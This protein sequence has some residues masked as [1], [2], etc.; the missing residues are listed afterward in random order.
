MGTTIALVASLVTIA[1]GAMFLWT[2]R[3][4]VKNWYS[5]RTPRSKSILD[6]RAIH[7]N[8][9]VAIQARMEDLLRS[10]EVSVMNMKGYS[11]L[12]QLSLMETPAHKLLS[13]RKGPS[14]RF[15]LHSP[16]SKSFE[17]RAKELNLP[18]GAE[19]SRSEFAENL[20]KLRTLSV[21]FPGRCASR[22]FDASMPLW[23]L[24]IWD[25]GM[26]VGWYGATSSARS[27]CV[28]LSPT[29]EFAQ[30]FIRYY[31]DIWKNESADA[32]RADALRSVF[33]ASRS[34]RDIAGVEEK[35]AL[36]Y[37][38]SSSREN[39][40]L[41]FLGGGAGSGKSTLAWRIA[42]RLG[43]RNVVSTDMVREILRSQAEGEEVLQAETWESWEH[44]PKGTAK[45]LLAGIALQAGAV[46]EGMGQMTSWC[47]EKG[48]PTIIEGIHVVASDWLAEMEKRNGN[49]VLFLDVDDSQLR[50]NYDNRCRATHM[51][52][53][54]ERMN[55]DRDRRDLHREI[56]ASAEQAGFHIVRG[57]TWKEIED[58]AVGYILS[59]LTHQ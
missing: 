8:R 18:Y 45:S 35:L 37:P 14:L 15:L 36:L 25:E 1:G 9:Q 21:K 38:D 23:N 16:D 58:S 17:V 40:F 52:G 29:S 54:D 46:I 3:I 20:R 33:P 49:V 28:E 51:R 42:S 44:L 12:G 47:L 30:R 50:V 32:M 41:I 24:V 7:P 53:P 43:V 2:R 5:H 4:R 57:S 11:L 34:L 31:E 27:W 22:V 10:E 13:Y 26:L 56:I 55:R 39:A 19:N 59:Q 48:M 6:I